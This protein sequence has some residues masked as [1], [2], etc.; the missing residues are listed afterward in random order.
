MIGLCPRWKVSL[1]FLLLLIPSAL[2]PAADRKLTVRGGSSDLGETPVVVAVPRDLATGPY[3]LVPTSGDP[4]N[5]QIF[6]DHGATLLG[7]VLPII[8]KKSVQEF[9][10]EPADDLGDPKVGVH[11]NATP[12]VIDVTLND[13]P[14]TTHHLDI[15][16]KPILYPIYGPT[17][18]TVTR[19]YPMK[20]V[21]GEDKDHPHHRSFWFTHGSVNGVDF[22]SELKGHGSIKETARLTAVDGP[23]L[24]R[25]RTTDD[26][27]APDGHVVCS[28]ERVITFY[29]TLKGRVLDFEITIKA[30]HGPVTFG[31]TKEGSFG[32]RVASSM[33][34]KPPALG[35]ITN[36]EGLT[37]DEA[38]GKA[39]PWVDYV[40]PVD[41]KTVGIAILNHP[42]SFRF[43]TN[44][45]VRTYGLFAANPFGYKDFGRKDPGAYTIPKGEKI[46]FGYRVVLHEGDTPSANVPEL[47][48]AYSESPVVE[49]QP[50]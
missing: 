15:G 34:A 2:A 23:A 13:K 3:R 39:S 32:L 48:Q 9:R 31:D 1:G 36:A 35:K 26:W 27:V 18:A 41:G 17:G 30:N 21:D 4:L 33:D 19:A 43:P 45:H 46:R 47:F 28:D 37:N 42:G 49:I 10:I 50:D 25:I 7:A 14:L 20:N 44:W 24:G 22:W 8:K 40:G 16:P 11:F 29:N 6:V 12:A 38:W 5:A